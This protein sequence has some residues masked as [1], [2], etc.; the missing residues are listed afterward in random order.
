MKRLIPIKKYFLF[1]LCLPIMIFLIPVIKKKT[2]EKLS[3]EP[4]EIVGNFIES[5]PATFIAMNFFIKIFL[6]S[7]KEINFLFYM[8]KVLN[9]NYR[10]Y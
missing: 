10:R 3:S 2:G 4:Q 6:P 7:V 9:L 1:V 8:Q 5:S